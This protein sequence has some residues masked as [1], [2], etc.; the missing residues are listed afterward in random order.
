M[1]SNLIAM[2][3]ADKI[4]GIGVC[5]KHLQCATNSLDRETNQQIAN[6]QARKGEN[7]TELKLS[8][9]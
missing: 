8:L 9:K 4:K 5:R 1:C 3:S 2:C 7:L 6:R